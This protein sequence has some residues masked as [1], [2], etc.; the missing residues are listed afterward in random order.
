MC[1]CCYHHTMWIERHLHSPVPFL[2]KN[3]I[4]YHRNDISKHKD[5]LIWKHL[6]HLQQPFTGFLEHQTHHTDWLHIPPKYTHLP[7]TGTLIPFLRIPSTAGCGARVRMSLF[8]NSIIFLWS[9]A[10]LGSAV[11]NVPNFMHCCPNKWTFTALL[12]S[13]Q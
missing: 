13:H 7:I 8:S 5:H 2:F 3:N 12:R 6:I 9:S 11:L 4:C 10:T 1:F